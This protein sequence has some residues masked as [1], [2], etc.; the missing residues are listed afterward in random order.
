VNARESVLQ[1]E[2]NDNAHPW[3]WVREL[4]GE[5]EAGSTTIRVGRQQIVWGKTDAFRLQD[6]VNPIDVGYHN[7]FPDL[8]ERR[9]PSLA[10]DLI[11]SF[12]SFGGLEDVSA[13]LVWVFD[14]FMPVQLGQCGEAYAFTSACEVRADAAG[15]GLLN[16]SLAGVEERDWQ[17]KNT[18]PGLRIEF[19]TP[20]PSIAFS[21][22]AF[23]GFQDA[24]AARF[25]NHYSTANP[26][27]AALLFLQ[28]Q[29]APVP[30]FDP[31]NAAAI[32]GASNALLAAYN[33]AVGAACPGL[34]QTALANCIT[35]NG[36]QALSL[37]WVASEAIA[38]YP[39]VLTLGGSADYQIPGVDTVLRTEVAFDFDRHI[40]DTSEIDGI[41]HSN[42][43]MAAIGLDRSTFIPFLN[44]NRTAFLSFQTFA[45]HIFSYES[46]TAGTV[47]FRTSWISTAFMQ[48]YWRND[49]IV[50]TNFVAFDWRSNAWI[51]GPSL[52]WV[53][54]DRIAVEGG[55]NLLWGERQKHNIRDLCAT[56]DLSCLG[57]P[58]TWQAGNWQAISSFF[59]REAESPFWA[60]ESFADLHTEQRDEFWL[61]VTYQF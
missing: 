52:K 36:L 58:T 39:R 5:F 30:V 41:G 25:T 49:S 15:H 29:G 31:Y 35:A 40:T 22:S 54:N 4:Y 32:L 47:P 24:P 34:V 26:N 53:V 38:Y 42:V 7:V 51:T 60:L 12:G 45:E 55:V 50:L 37:P 21:L 56:G 10:F 3:C 43:L 59:A 57:D 1:T 28:A 14:R 48:N 27:P 17:L 23:W 8:E 33:G 44:A 16:L 61:G 20:E 11:H 2:C 13:E 6:I 9:I 19:R 46:D 18:E